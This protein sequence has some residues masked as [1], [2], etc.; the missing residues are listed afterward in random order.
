MRTF[1]E[2]VDTVLSAIGQPSLLHLIATE[3]NAIILDLQTNHPSPYDMI[4]QSL[5]VGVSSK[6]FWTMPHDFHAIRAV[7]MDNQFFAPEA[8][9]GLVQKKLRRYWYQ[10][11]DSIVFIGARHKIDIA[12][13][14]SRRVFKYV[15]VDKRKIKSASDEHYDYAYRQNP[16]DNADNWVRYHE[17]LPNALVSYNAHVNWVIRK[18][19]EAILHGVMSTIFNHLGQLEKGARYYQRYNRSKDIIRRE[20]GLH[21]DAEI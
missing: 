10:S 7:R 8:K 1:S 4:E 15:K 11:S 5:R 19:P 12:Y 20:Q 9:P 16:I 21:T 13:Y 2:I 3:T 18:Y 6:Q 14:K 17:N